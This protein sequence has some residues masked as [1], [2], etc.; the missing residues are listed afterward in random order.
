MQQLERLDLSGTKITN[1]G[2]LALKNLPKLQYLGLGNTKVSGEGIQFLQQL[3]NLRELSLSKSKISGPDLAPLGGLNKL[4]A[5]DLSGTTMTSADLAMLPQID[6]L[7]RLQ[8]N[9][10]VREGHIDDLA[11][12]YLQKQPSLKVL[13]LHWNWL[14][15]G[16]AKFLSN[17]KHLK[18]LDISDSYFGAKGLAEIAK[19]LNLY[20]LEARHLTLDN[21]S[22][23]ALQ[24]CPNLRLLNIAQCDGVTDDT[25]ALIAKIKSIESLNLSEISK[26]TPKTVAILADEMPQLKELQLSHSQVIDRAAL[27][28]LIKLKN[29][30]YLD[31]TGV[32]VPDKDRNVKILRADLTHCVIKTD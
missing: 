8:L 23:R 9:N 28:E 18:R 29:L 32:S 7:E 26:L 4:K 24:N 12:Q 13:D 15:D 19:S 25:V 10:Q 21:D 5:L 17:L 6:A 20:E 16:C 14:T 30:R 22:I 31:L 27:D 1:H 3:K 11:I 2:L